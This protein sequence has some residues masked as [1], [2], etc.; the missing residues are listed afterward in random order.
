MERGADE[1]LRT[2]W[3][4]TDLTV[5]DIHRRI[6]ALDGAH[7]N[8]PTS[9]YS[10]AKRLGLPAVRNANSGQPQGRTVEE[11]DEGEAR[12]MILAGRGAKD[13]AEEFGWTLSRAQEF[14]TKVRMEKRGA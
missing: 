8:N 9:L 10:A 7:I 14:A 1:L 12:T 4:Q 13:V 5:K 3:P 2:L 6:N 11:E